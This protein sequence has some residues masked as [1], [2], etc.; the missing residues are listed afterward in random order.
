MARRA[1]A[2]PSTQGR[3]EPLAGEFFLG[4]PS[5]GFFD[6]RVNALGQL[7]QEEDPLDNDR[8]LSQLPSNIGFKMDWC[9]R[10]CQSGPDVDRQSVKP[11]LSR[12]YNPH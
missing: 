1:N 4:H 3:A 9:R 8:E 6:A 11:D 7:R 5:A 10:E 12:A 2:A